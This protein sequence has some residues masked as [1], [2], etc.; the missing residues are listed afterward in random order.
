M[1]RHKT[2]K[3]PFSAQLDAILLLHMVVAAVAIGWLLA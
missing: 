3:Q 1:F 2:R